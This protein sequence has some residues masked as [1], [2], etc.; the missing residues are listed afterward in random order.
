M[1]NA[2]DE[3][4]ATPTVQSGGVTPQLLIV[5]VDSVQVAAALI[6]PTEGEARFIASRPAI[7][8]EPHRGIPGALTRLTAQCGFALADATIVATIV[9]GPPI[10]V[11]VVGK[12]TAADA[13][14]LASAE[15]FGVARM[16]AAPVTPPRNPTRDRAWYRPVIDA[17]RDGLIEAL[18]VVVPPGILPFWAAQ[19]LTALGEVPTGGQGRVLLLTSDAD[20][21]DTV[22][23]DAIV[24][25]R[26]AHQASHLS[27]A[28]NRLRAARLLHGSAAD[29]AILARTEALAVAA[30][31]VSATCGRP[32]VYLDVADGTTVIVADENGVAV[33]H[34][35]EIDYARGAARL[36]NRCEAARI[37]RWI[38][39]AV[40]TSALRTWAL[41][42]ISAPTALLADEE[43]RV[44]AAGFARAALVMALE[45]ITLPIPDGAMWVL[46]PAL[47]RLGSHAAVLRIVADLMPSAR[48]AIVTCDDDDLIPAVGALSVSHP[49]D[50]SSLLAHD[51]LVPTGSV[52]QESSPGRRARGVMTATLAS[53]DR[54]VTIEVPPD[55]L[56]A[57]PWLTSATF[58]LTAEASSGDRISVEGGPGGILIDTRRRPLTAVTPHASRPSVSGRL[59]PAAAPNGT[60]D[61]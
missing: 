51:A 24:L 54:T 21:A 31:V 34:D 29:A 37:T 46:G 19:F 56:T 16:V 61:R 12:R 23:A 39:F 7:V 27:G 1:L 48:V 43:D 9:A 35:P 4:S 53:N 42:R 44:I 5:T 36:L 30:R 26:D 22:P 49:A 41:R 33:H 55:T 14:A 8:D 40:S 15:R 17:W 50:A 59:R 20:L 60:S 25:P 6:A 2:A 32:C 3:A 10:A 45:T 11:R 13:T 57:I 58:S 18:L 28:L 47:A 38:P 52:V